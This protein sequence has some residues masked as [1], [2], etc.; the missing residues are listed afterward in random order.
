MTNTQT[1]Y[2]PTQEE[3]EA[4][5]KRSGFKYGWCNLESSARRMAEHALVEL[6]EARQVDKSDISDIEMTKGFLKHLGINFNETTEHTR[7]HGVVKTLECI[8]ENGKIVSYA[9]DD[10]IL[11]FE[12]SLSGD[13]IEIYTL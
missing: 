8:N 11:H 5:I 12:F 13:F 9:E 7:R 2:E 1:N 10:I 3:L 6:H 4:F